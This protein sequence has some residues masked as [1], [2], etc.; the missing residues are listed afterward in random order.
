MADRKRPSPEVEEYRRRMEEA[1]ETLRAIRQGKV[2]ALVISG[3]QGEQVFTLKDAD[4]PYRLMIEEMREGAV[5]L[6]PDGAIIFAN[7]ASPR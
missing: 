1:E 7:S 5:I 6:R 3:E 4:R 2:D